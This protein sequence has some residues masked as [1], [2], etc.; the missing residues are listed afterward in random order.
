MTLPLAA[1]AH[2]AGAPPAFA[3]SVALPSSTYDGEP[4]ITTAPDGTL[5]VVSPCSHTCV[6]R[7]L[8]H[9]A[10]WARVHDSLGASGDS[11]AVVD[12]AGTLY[13]SD[14]F[15]SVPV[16]V[17]TDRGTSFGFSSNSIGTNSV[18][19]QWL[20]TYGA[21][22]VWSGVHDT[23]DGSY[24]VAHSTDGARTWAQH[25]AFT[26]ASFPPPG[27]MIATSANDLYIPYPST[28]G[29][30]RVSVSHDA[31]AT[32]ASHDVAPYKASIPLGDTSIFPSIAAD[33]NGVLYL[34]W[35]DASAPTSVPQPA[36]GTRVQ[37]AVSHDL[38]ASWSQPLTLSPASDY[39][40]DPWVVA[41]AAGHVAVTWYD[42]VP[43]AVVQ[44]TPGVADGTMWHVAVA[45]AQ[46]ADSA[47]PQWTVTAATGVTHIGPICETGTGCVPEPNPVAQNRILLDFFGM[48]EQSDGTLAITYAGDQ[49]TPQAR[50]TGIYTQL[51]AVAQD[52]GPGLK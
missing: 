23:G 25:L 9:G 19:R 35:S 34:V 46:D 37:I 11:D 42:G 17:S 12:A 7:S 47:S 31:G 5:Y 14:L 51:Y 33:V 40:I 20:A 8:D 13:V 48:T 24:Q 50:A 3:A 28:D 15:N 6:W 26:D 38:G 10:S 30:V 36:F 21:G 45:Y 16:S 4:G 52:G 49:P 18:D 22:N 43:P 27:R 29:S 44:T 39:A 32:W 41:D 2:G 1:P